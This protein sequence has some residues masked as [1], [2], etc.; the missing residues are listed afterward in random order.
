[1]ENCLGALDDTY[2]KVNVNV[3]DRPRYRTKKGVIATNVLVVCDTN[4]DFIFVLPG[5]E[6]SATDSQVLRNAISRPHGLKVPKGK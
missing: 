6:G 2:F 3:I 5:W 1:M 4:G